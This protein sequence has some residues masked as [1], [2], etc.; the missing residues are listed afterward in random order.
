MSDRSLFSTL[1]R[2]LSTGLLALLPVGLTVA[3]L[4]W[5]VKFLAD[6]LGPSSQVGVMLRQIGWN[7][8]ESDLGAYAGGMLFALVLI[9]LLGLLV[10]TVLKDRWGRWTDGLT[11]RIPVIRTV[12]DASKKIVE[13]MEPKQGTDMQSMQPIMCDFGGTTFPAFL[14]T[15]Q[16]FALNGTEYHVVMIPTAPVPFGG[17]IMCVPKDAVS[18]LDCGID[19]LFNIYM[20]MGTM[21][22]DYIKK[23]PPT[24][25]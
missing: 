25:E 12:Y 11:S 3:I 4:A 5:L 20:S 19:G 1:L 24:V 8:G 23:T 7:F 6:M 14:P 9:Y 13:M 10:G 17:A 22:P 21:V 2:P 18:P 16:T 15:S